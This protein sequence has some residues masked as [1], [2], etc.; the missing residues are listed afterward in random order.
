M[1]TRGLFVLNHVLRGR[2]NAP[3][4]CVDTTPVPTEPGL[5]QR[6][7]AEIRLADSSCAGCHRR[8]EPLAFSLERFDG[9]GAWHRRDQH[10]NDLR[11]NGEILF[12]G[13]EKAVTY[14]TT[15]ELANLLADSPR[16]SETITWKLA[17]FS[18]G[19][20]LMAGDLPELNAIHETARTNGGTYAAVMTALLTSELVR[21][22]R[23]ESQ[24]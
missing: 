4:A 16:V 5:S 21:M 1:V 8:F 13:A 19:R 24:P 14:E 11:Q 20:P 15:A 2:V 12:P 3:P 7:I 22:S 23:T 10:G 17:Q 9:I 18:L 6:R